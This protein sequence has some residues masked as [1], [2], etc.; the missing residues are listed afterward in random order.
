MLPLRILERVV[1]KFM[2]V[3]G[4]EFGAFELV[5]PITRFPLKFAAEHSFC[6]YAYCMDRLG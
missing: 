6:N 5:T 2:A 4:S 3:E 1:V